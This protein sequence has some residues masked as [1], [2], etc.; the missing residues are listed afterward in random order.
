MNCIKYLTSL[1]S[2]NNETWRL[3]WAGHDQR[4]D[5][6]QI[7]RRVFKEK[8]EGRRLVGQA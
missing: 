6:P 3:T 7:R 8:T 4:M 1:K 2:E 5:D